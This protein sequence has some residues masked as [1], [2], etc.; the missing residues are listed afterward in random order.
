MFLTFFLGTAVIYCVFSFIY[1]PLVFY[2]T[3]IFCGFVGF[4]VF[5]EALTKLKSNFLFP[6]SLFLNVGA[7][8]PT[9]LY[10]SSSS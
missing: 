4:S 6:L 3:S 2:S 8:G 5:E 9:Y 7:L 10:Y 1:F